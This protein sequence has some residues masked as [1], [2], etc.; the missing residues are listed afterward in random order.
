MDRQGLVGLLTGAALAAG[1]VSGWAASPAD[2]CQAG[3][4]KAA[5]KLEACRHKALAKYAIT[6]DATKRDTDLARCASRHATTWQALEAK[7]IAQGGACRTVGDQA[8]IHTYAEDY[9]EDV[10][11]ALAGGPLEGGVHGFRLRTGLTTCWNEAGAQI[12]CAGTGQDGELQAGLSPFYLD[13]GAGTILDTR[14]GFT[15]EKQSD[16]GSIHD[17]NNTYVWADAFAKVAT[18]NATRFAGYA[19]WRVPNVNELHSIV[20]Y[21]TTNPAT[22]LAFNFGCAPGCTV[23]TCSCSAPGLGFY[24]MSNTAQPGYGDAWALRLDDGTL[25]TVTTTATYAVRAVRGGV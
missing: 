21:S 7:A 23:Q 19:D 11:A 3:K 17:R 18:L 10:A 14:T 13:I 6:V 15:W 22:P 2:T 8:D 9:T 25:F 1:I 20:S 5:G 12:A 4:N 16:D 24:W